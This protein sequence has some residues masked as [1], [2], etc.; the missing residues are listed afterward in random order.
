MKKK[1][2]LTIDDEFT[3]Y[4]KLNNIEDVE[5]FA[6]E[7]FNKSFTIIKYG[8]KP[9]LEKVEIRTP[10]KED[11]IK[12]WE[13]LDGLKPMT[14]DEVTKIFEPSPVQ[15]VPETIIKK[16]DIYDE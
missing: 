9:K 3:Q 14:S 2:Y 1:Y 15:V 11:I 6:K 4:C 5:K 12:K 13:K 16:K 7:I 10:T 8:D